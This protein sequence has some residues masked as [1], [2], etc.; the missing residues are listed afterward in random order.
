ME[1]S[2]YPNPATSYVNVEVVSEEAQ[3]FTA[4]VVDMMGRTVY[5]DQFNHNGGDQVYQL[6]VNDLAKG[7]YVLHLNS[8]KGSNVQRFVVE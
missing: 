1:V 7:I 6:P 5:V 3:Q 8:A 4:K 2:V